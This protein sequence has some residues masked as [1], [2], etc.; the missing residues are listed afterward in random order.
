MSVCWLSNR[1]T[2]CGPASMRFLAV[3]TPSPR[4]PTSSTSIC[5]SA[6]IMRLPYSPSIRLRSSA[7]AAPTRLMASCIGAEAADR[8]W[9]EDM[10]EPHSQQADTGCGA[11][12]GEK[13]WDER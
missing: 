4:S 3:S 12:C 5:F 6:P 8:V 9:D 10:T 13:E 11:R 1:V 2:L 7:A